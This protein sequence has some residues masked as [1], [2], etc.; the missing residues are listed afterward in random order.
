[1][2]KLL[3]QI[4]CFNEAQTLPQTLAALPRTVAGFDRVEWLIIDDGSTDGTA[5][6]A[7]KHGV[8]H[9][10]NAGPNQGPGPRVHGGHRACLKAGRTSSSI[11]TPI[12]STRRLNSRLCN[13][14]LETARR[15]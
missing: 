14:I 11:R 7:R 2:R 6:V 1:M 12:T 10:V 9:V 13:P 8:D 5:E 4:P 3:I 15:S